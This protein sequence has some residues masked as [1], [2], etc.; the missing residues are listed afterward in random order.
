[1]VIQWLRIEFGFGIWNLGLGA[2]GLG[3][4]NLNLE[5]FEP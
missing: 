3:L 1:M 5:L 4:K 2:W